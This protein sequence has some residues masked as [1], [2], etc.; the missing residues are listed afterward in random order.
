MVLKAD[1]DRLLLSVKKKGKVF[2]L[3]APC[4][5]EGE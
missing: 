4:A 5:P 3:Q 1:L 2:P